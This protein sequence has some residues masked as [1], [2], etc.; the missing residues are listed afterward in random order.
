MVNFFRRQYVLVNVDCV[1]MGLKTFNLAYNLRQK[2]D[3]LRRTSLLSLNAM[4][5]NITFQR[6]NSFILNNQ[7]LVLFIGNYKRNSNKGTMEHKQTD[8]TTGA[9]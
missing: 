1:P 4:H 6:C 3:T 5:S 8:K 2:D 7:K 9:R